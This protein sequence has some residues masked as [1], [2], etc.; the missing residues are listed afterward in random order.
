MP[1]PVHCFAVNVMMP[2]D[3]MPRHDFGIWSGMAV[4]L[5]YYIYTSCCPHRVTS[6]KSMFVSLILVQITLIQQCPL[7]LSIQL[8]LLRRRKHCTSRLF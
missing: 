3:A 7:T 2:F 4:L 1:T 6:Y 5:Q 8:L